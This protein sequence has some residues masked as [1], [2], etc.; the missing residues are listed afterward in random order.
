MFLYE[1]ATFD[2]K[3]LETLQYIGK[4]R[5]NFA[6][7]NLTGSRTMLDYLIIIIKNS[8]Y[9]IDVQRHFWYFHLPVYEAC[10]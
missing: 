1:I 3:F 7:F 4:L 9:Q 2:I 5:Q 10:Y 6:T 8:D